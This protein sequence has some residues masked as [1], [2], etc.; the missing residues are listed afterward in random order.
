MVSKST[1]RAFSAAYIMGFDAAHHKKPDH[2]AVGPLA[3]TGHRDYDTYTSGFDKGVTP[4]IDSDPTLSSND[5]KLAR[6]LVSHL[7]EKLVEMSQAQFEPDQAQ[8]IRELS[9][10]T[11]L[12][13]E[14]AMSENWSELP[15]VSEYLAEPGTEPTRKETAKDKA[16]KRATENVASFAAR[17]KP[18]A[19]KK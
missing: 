17:F 18:K 5:R 13:I 2:E 14:A 1:I 12:V 10:R 15:E 7:R 8:R 4:N 6:A 16:A 9:G 3:K 19:V 11:A